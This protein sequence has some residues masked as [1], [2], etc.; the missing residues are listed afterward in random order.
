M[1]TRLWKT[2]R[3]ARVFESLNLNFQATGIRAGAEAGPPRRISQKNLSPQ[4]SENQ[5]L[6]DKCQKKL[7]KRCEKV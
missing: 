3:A 2:S 1:L 5:A 6:F 7:K 4:P